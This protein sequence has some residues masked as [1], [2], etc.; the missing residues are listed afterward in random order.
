MTQMEAMDWLRIQ[1]IPVLNGFNATQAYMTA[2]PDATYKSARYSG[3]RLMASEQFCISMKMMEHL[4][5]RHLPYLDQP[6]HTQTV[7]TL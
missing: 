2:F 5:L 4:R 7:R 1:N 6:I 3:Y